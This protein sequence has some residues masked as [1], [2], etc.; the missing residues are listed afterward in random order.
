MKPD[1]SSR[2]DI[3]FIITKFY[4]KLLVDDKMIPF[5]KEIVAQNH[6][7]AHLEVITDFWSDILFDTYS[8][9]N[10]VMKK[11]VDKNAFV[12]FKKEHFTIWTSY[13]FETI[14]TFFDGSIADNMKN[15]ARSIATVMQLKMKLY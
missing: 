12:E 10:N 15:R 7:E 6:L 2:K 14:D 9:S 11:H 13:F 4:D 3:K 1:I 5:F 8:Y